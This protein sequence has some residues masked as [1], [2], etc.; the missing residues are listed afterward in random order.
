MQ[1]YRYRFPASG[2][3]DELPESAA[4]MLAGELTDSPDCLMAECIF[5]S[6]SNIVDHVEFE[7]KGNDVAA[8]N[9]YTYT[10]MWEDIPGSGQSNIQAL[11]DAVKY[12]LEKVT[13]AVTITGDGEA[14]GR[15]GGI[16]KTLYHI[17]DRKNMAAIE[18]EGL[19]PD[20]G[21][22]S[23]KVSEDCVYLCDGQNI[24]PW[25]G[26]LKGIDDPVVLEID[27]DGLSGIETGRVFEDRSYV[28]GTYSEYRT[29][30]QIPAAAVTKIDFGRGHEELGK[31]I[32]D[33][34]E[35]Y[36][37]RAA[38]DD[39]LSE[40]QTGMQRLEQLGIK[41][42]EIRKDAASMKD[43][44]SQDM[45]FGELPWDD[46]PKVPEKEPYRYRFDIGYAKPGMPMDNQMA[47]YESGRME[48]AVK[49]TGTKGIEAVRFEQE[50]DGA[51][52]YV[53]IYTKGPWN[54]DRLESHMEKAV[55]LFNRQSDSVRIGL[56]QGISC[57][58]SK[59]EEY[60]D[61][62]SDAVAR[63]RT[64]EETMTK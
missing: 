15:E 34:I 52:K 48:D 64:D 46:G 4:S 41:E 3:A 51:V 50:P 42:D 39:G 57:G 40:V 2:K 37:A 26:I 44:F 54:P 33:Q 27:T 18:Q 63:I 5:P 12:N 1:T 28:D 8:V 36:M 60:G 29:T 19:V 53:S 49:G 20:S 13:D 9:L 22:N 6:D 47:P 61:S 59:V 56:G 7:T 35:G 14:M 25:L 23:W 16:P 43:G 10:E 45:D 17:T 55:S 11:T 31:L 38:K 30:E 21:K 58:R 24:A 62:F 32:R